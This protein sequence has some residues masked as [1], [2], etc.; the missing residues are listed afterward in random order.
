[1]TALIPYSVSLEC[2]FQTMSIGNIKI[3]VIGTGYVDM[4]IAMLFIWHHHVTAVDVVS[5][6]VKLINRSKSPIHDG[7][8]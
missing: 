5:E 8:I 6:K 1:M 7:I 3:A 4:R 2:C